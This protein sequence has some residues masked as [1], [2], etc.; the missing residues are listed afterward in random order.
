[1]RR[2]LALLLV[3][4][5]VVAGACNSGKKA[6]TGATPR[7]GGT[8]RL[9]IATPSSLD[10]AQARTIEETL[11]A[12]Q[13]F[14]GLTT[15]DPKTLQPVPALTSGWTSSPDL[16]QWDFTIRPGATFANGRAI[17]ATDVK[18]TFER[19]AHKDSGSPAS[20]LLEPITGYADVAAGKTNDLAGVTAPS[21]NVV[22][23]NVD[24][25]LAVL[26]ALLASPL[27]GIVSPE[28]V[29]VQPPAAPFNVAPTNG[30]GSFTFQSNKGDVIRLVRRK[31]AKAYL[32]AI[33]AH[34][35]K[36]VSAAYAAFRRGAV[37]WSRVPP[38]NVAAAGARYGRQLFTPY[39]AELFYGFNLK[40]PKL[41]DVRF[42]QAIVQAVDTSAI[43][44]AVYQ[45]TVLP[46]KGVVVKGVPGYHTDMCGQACAYNPTN[47]KKLVSDV[48]Q[49]QAPPEIFL[50]FDE[51][52][53]QRAVANAISTDLKA[54]G[55]TGT[56][57]PHAP[58]DYA[59]FAASGGQE[60]FRLGW[61]APFPSADAFLAPLFATGSRS[62]LTAF[63]L[64]GVDSELAA[65]RAQPK[66]DAR[67]AAYQK[68]EG[69]VLAQ[70]PMLPIAQFQFQ[71]VASA[72][73]HGI[74]PT[75]LATFDG[76]KVWI[77]PV[78]K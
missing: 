63:S 68:I 32:S 40:S 62:N 38:D 18:F 34:K 56:L 74:V 4:A 1:M 73:V 65:A 19:V 2:S 47:A 29:G 39:V 50:D 78:A 61:I 31:G 36:D 57:R 76:S 35:Y 55:I 5:A 64:P 30:S 41:A 45:S 21:P 44:K 69:E 42:R 43:I 26:P 7:A 27:L 8:L 58:A 11:L 33:E 12:D 72:N 53:V 14:D 13:M 37:D 25:P 75:A 10:P 23:I 70:M 59:Q 52:E 48:F 15:Y 6:A 51:D 28:A 20:D 46:I 22:R 16:K 54:V 66:E 67:E 71:A 17:V 60:V 9:G 49:G 3:L 24:Q 77:E